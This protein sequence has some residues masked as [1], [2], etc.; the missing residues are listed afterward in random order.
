MKMKMSTNMRMKLNMNI[1][2]GEGVDEDEGEAG[3]ESCL[4]CIPSQCTLQMVNAEPS[5]NSDGAPLLVPH[6]TLRP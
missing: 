2:E 6:R 5:R 3:H 4:T 1:D